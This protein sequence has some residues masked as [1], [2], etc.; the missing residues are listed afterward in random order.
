LARTSNSK[1]VSHLKTPEHMSRQA[2]RT[3]GALTKAARSLFEEHGFH[4]CRINDI[5]ERAGVSVGTFYTYFGSKEDIFRALL[6]QVEDEVYGELSSSTAGS[7]SPAENIAQTNR[8]YLAAFR[9]NARFWTVL[10]EAAL[11]DPESAKLL[12]DRR[13]Y[14]QARTKRAL[15]RWQQRGEIAA[16]IDTEFTAL[17]LGAMTE[18]CAYIWFVYGLPVDLE[19]ADDQLTQLWLRAIGLQDS[20]G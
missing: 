16:D 5:T 2:L 11:T 10:E 14:Y 1:F 6:A 4:N 20:S 9:R 18:R 13:R 7:D 3:K 17:A 12:G 15:D 19:S 8:L